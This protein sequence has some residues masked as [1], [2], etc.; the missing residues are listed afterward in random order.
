MPELPEVETIRLALAPRLAGRSIS[1]AWGHE[2]AKFNQAA[3]ATGAQV[4]T[5]ARRG[6]Y[7]LADLDLGATPRQLVIHL[8]MTGVLEMRQPS[9]PADGPY[10][11]AWWALDDGTTLVF[12]DVRRFG[13]VAVVPSG[14]HR[15][16]STLARLGP[17]PFSDQFTPQH[18][19]SGVAATNRA[20]K[21]ALLAQHIVAGLGNI[22]ADEALWRAGVDPRRRS[23]LGS[24]RAQRL[25]AAIRSALADGLARGGTTLRD[26]RNLDGGRGTNQHRLEVYG[27]AGQ[28][29]LRCGRTLRSTV[30]DARTTTWCVG[31]Q[32]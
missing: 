2:S 22:Y 31:C 15:S 9:E 27:R 13:R 8:G 18:L 26:Y 28:P 21:T 30:L 6:K 14:D 4:G 7:L 16:L 10:V 25:H 23:G 12:N 3:S 5:L 29:C 19:R 11:R 20:I 17:E 32:R 1:E 24:A